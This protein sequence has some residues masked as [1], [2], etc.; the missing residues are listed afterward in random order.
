MHRAAANRFHSRPAVFSHDLLESG[1]S[2][3]IGRYQAPGIRFV[4]HT[5]DE[6]F[7]IRLILRTET[8]QLVPQTLA[9]RAGWPLVSTPSEQHRARKRRSNDPA[10]GDLYDPV[11]FFVPSW[12]SSCLHG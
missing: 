7:P 12:Q 6:S 3:G 9:G 8:K 5:R 10:N 2:L 1:R 4:L 11:F